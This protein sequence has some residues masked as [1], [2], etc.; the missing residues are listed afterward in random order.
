M[1]GGLF[2]KKLR[3]YLDVT[4][5]WKRS[6]KIMAMS[7]L[8]SAAVM[9]NSIVLISSGVVVDLCVRHKVAKSLPYLHSLATTANIGS[10]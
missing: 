10:L 1:G 5:N 4:V 3:D 6:L 8:R 2:D 7:T 9:N